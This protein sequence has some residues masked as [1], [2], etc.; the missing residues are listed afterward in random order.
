MNYKKCYLS[1]VLKLLIILS[2][3]Y[4]GV[5]CTVIEHVRSVFAWFFCRMEVERWKSS[6]WML[7]QG[8]IRAY[9][10]LRRNVFSGWVSDEFLS[11][12]V[13]VKVIMVVLMKKWIESFLEIILE[14]R[15]DWKSELKFYW[16]LE[17]ARSRMEFTIGYKELNLELI[18][19][20]LSLNHRL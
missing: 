3:L 2:V 14:I 10:Y 5:L 18:I 1:P 17:G 13:L 12:G 4:T 7:F 15:I 20:Y 19:R 11:S 8:E 9:S 6:A 16:K